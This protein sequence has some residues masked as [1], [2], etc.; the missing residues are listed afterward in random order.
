MD[1][2]STDRR[3]PKTKKQLRQ[4]LTELLEKSI[5]TPL[6]YP[7]ASDFYRMGGK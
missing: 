3:V 5:F 4:S 2:K 7:A 6:S 1:H